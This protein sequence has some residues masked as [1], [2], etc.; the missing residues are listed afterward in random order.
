MGFDPSNRS[1]VDEMLQVCNSDI[2]KGC[3]VNMSG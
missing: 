1:L 2:S 3:A